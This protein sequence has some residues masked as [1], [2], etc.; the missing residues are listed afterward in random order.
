MQCQF[1]LR[2]LALS[3]KYFGS[4]EL[5]VHLEGDGVA[6]ACCAKLLSDSGQ[7]F[8]IAKVVRPQL[9]AVLLSRQ[10][11]ALLMEIFPAAGLNSACH[12]IQ[13][14][15]VSWGAAAAPLT[16]PHSASVV[17]QA[18]LLSRLWSQVP[19]TVAQEA[20]D[21]TFVAACKQEHFGTRIAS[22]A[23]VALKADADQ[24]TCWIE[25][26]D[27]GWLFLLPPATLIAVGESP[28]ILL[29]QSRLIGGVVDRLDGSSA[30]FPAYPRI[31]SPLGGDGWLACG[32]AAVG[33]DPL[34]G[35]GTGHAVRQ[36]YLATALVAAV[37]AGEPVGALLAH[38]SSRQVQAFHRHL[39]TCLSFYET[40]G[41]TAFWQQ[42]TAILRQGI[43]WTEQI[44]RQQAPPSH[45]L[46]GRR[47][48]PITRLDLR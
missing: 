18:E 25:S 15:I 30:R 11:I 13:Q 45:R 41:T 38:Y 10:T 31:A 28:D 14:R 37:R 21:W 48:H 9:G 16:V 42:E 27:S 47:L 46:V 36:A 17:S 8:S 26:L 4:M 20:A 5:K 43:E 44:L 35:E 12:P 33:F 39:Q 7:P 1:M 32:A 29:G 24:T 34:C 23:R 40:G 2:R 6:A 19:G 22:V 3:V